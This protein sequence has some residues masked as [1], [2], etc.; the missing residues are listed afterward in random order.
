MKVDALH[1]S[2][3]RHPGG[4]LLRARRQY[5]T[6][7]RIL[8]SDRSFAVSSR[9]IGILLYTNTAALCPTVTIL[10][11][12]VAE[13]A[14]QLCGRVGAVFSKQWFLCFHKHKHFVYHICLCYSHKIRYL[15]I[16]HALFKYLYIYTYGQSGH[17][18]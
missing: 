2:R 11:N 8:P 18:W 16:W 17:R 4:G 15:L 7:C 6:W 1:P 10:Q 9:S 14:A 5:Q 13:T 3:Q 12:G